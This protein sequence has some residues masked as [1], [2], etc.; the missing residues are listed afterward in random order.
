MVCNCISSFKWPKKAMPGDSIF[1]KDAVQISSRQGQISI[2][3]LVSDKIEIDGAYKSSNNNFEI[4]RGY[5]Q[6]SLG[7]MFK[8]D[9]AIC[10]YSKQSIALI[11]TKKR[12]R[13]RALMVFLVT[14]FFVFLP[15]LIQLFNSFAYFSI[16]VNISVGQAVVM[17]LPLAAC[18][19]VISTWKRLGSVLQ[20]LYRNVF[21]ESVLAQEGEAPSSI[22][23]IGDNIDFRRE[24]GHWHASLE[25]VC[26]AEPSLPAA[27]LTGAKGDELPPGFFV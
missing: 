4:P 22:E 16:N 26:Q 23:I 18:I 19:S 10:Q 2:H 3:F 17:S 25:N 7:L 20:R 9:P 5:D 12:L 24:F 13:I 8:F 15:S 27:V 11:V 6:L 21:I 14:L 1:I